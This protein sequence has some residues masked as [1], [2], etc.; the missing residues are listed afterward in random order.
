V[1]AV[2]GLGGFSG[3]TSG[4]KLEVKSWLL[5]HETRKPRPCSPQAFESGS[6]P[7][8]PDGLFPDAV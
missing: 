2:N 8:Y 7:D 1:V 6:L 4:R 5:S 3:D